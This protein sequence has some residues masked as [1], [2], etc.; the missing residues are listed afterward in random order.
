[1]EIADEF[2]IPSKF[3]MQERW[4]RWGQ[5]GKGERCQAKKQEYARQEN[6]KTSKKDMQEVLMPEALEL[7]DY[8]DTGP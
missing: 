4:K 6:G 1:M 8:P 7:S 2:S 5:L 3:G